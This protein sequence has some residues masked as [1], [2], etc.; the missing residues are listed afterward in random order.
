MAALVDGSRYTLLV[1][2][3][4]SSRLRIYL[5]PT[6]ILSCCDTRR[7]DSEQRGPSR[8]AAAPMAAAAARDRRVH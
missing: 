3:A 2:S 8:A 7:G 6:V 1:A 4:I 5:P